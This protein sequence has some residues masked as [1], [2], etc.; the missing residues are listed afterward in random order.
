VGETEYSTIC[1]IR[2]PRS[3][4]LSLHGILRVHITGKVE[5]P[6]ERNSAVIHYTMLQ[7][8]S[9]LLL[10]KGIEK[11][12][13]GIME[14]DAF[15]PLKKISKL[16]SRNPKKIKKKTKKVSAL[17]Q[18]ISHMMAWVPQTDLSFLVLI[19]YDAYKIV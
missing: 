17:H 13:N 14:G 12:K 2:S 4:H 11:Y 10:S 9:V 1:V 8:K 16:I 15:L 3:S 18:Y 5:R 6:P 7:R 19:N